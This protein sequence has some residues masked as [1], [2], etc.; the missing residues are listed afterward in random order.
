MRSA[1]CR[2]AR[3]IQN[4]APSE[5]LHPVIVADQVGLR[6]PAGAL[7]APPFGGDPLRAGGRTHAMRDTA[8]AEPDRR[9]VGYRSDHI[10]RLRP[11]QQ[12]DRSRRGGIV[13]PGRLPHRQRR[14][15]PHRAFRDMAGK[16]RDARHAV[17]TQAV[18][19]GVDHSR[20]T[21]AAIRRGEI[22]KPDLRRLHWRHDLGFQH[23]HLDAEA[24]VDGIQL[25]AQQPGQMRR[26][27]SR[28]RGIHRD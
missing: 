18:A 17:Q 21:I 27:A 19:Q 3:K 4:R 12:A 15:S 11:A 22:G 9:I 14:H 23:D 7:A 2:P 8:P 10:D 5:I 20:Q 13:H 1:A 28:Q 26:I 6:P 24:R 25:L 16:R